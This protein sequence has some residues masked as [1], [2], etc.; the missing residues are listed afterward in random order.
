MVLAVCCNFCRL[1]SK[2][3]ENLVR[4]KGCLI[5]A[6]L[7]GTAAL[8]AVPGGAANAATAL[9]QLPITNLT[10]V[11]ADG[12]DGYVFL[13]T[14]T[15]VVVT[16]LNGAQV[17]TLEAGEAPVALATDNTH[18]FVA[19]AGSDSIGEFTE[20]TLGAVKTYALP[21]G[22]K[23]SSIAYQADKI[24]VSYSS[25]AV[26]GA[27]GYFKVGSATFVPNALSATNAWATA[28]RLAADPNPATQGTLVAADTGAIAAYNVSGYTGKPI[29]T[30]VAQLNLTTCAG[31]LADMA[32]TANG[33]QVVLACTG[34]TKELGFNAATLAAVATANYPGGA[35]PDAIAISDDNTGFATGTEDATAPALSV[36]RS[37]ATVPVLSDPLAAANET[38]APAGLS[39]T[40][41]AIR[42][43]A[44]LQNTTSG[45]YYL[46]VLEFPQY[47]P[48][49]ISI[50]PVG[51][52]TFKAG[53]K[54]KLKG[55]LTLGTAGTAAVPA[56]IKLKIYRQVFGTN[57]TSGTITTT[58]VA[59]GAYTA[60][61]IPPKHGN[62]TYLAYYAGGA[63]APAYHQ[64]LVHVTIAKPALALTTSA[65]SVKAGKTVTV[66]AHLGNPHTNR[67][68][69]IYAQ[70]KGGAKKVIKHANVNAKGV[71]S[72]SYKITANTTFTVTFSGDSWYTA[73][74]AT[75]T[76]KG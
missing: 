47:K 70:P 19:A 8:L 17:G 1:I 64:C 54:V 13:D 23:P 56:G 21:A 40:P 38:V 15:S 39:W 33:G 18:V 51:G 7:F 67:T 10:Q 3:V 11:L 48:S 61:D 29:G 30:P 35:T 28:P 59:G 27:V 20:A 26:T 75:A 45:A 14:A 37:G 36:F 52:D 62:Y 57:V 41:D 46:D 53:T 44:V 22:D 34:N 55:T 12:A 16:N 25:P 31:M 71:L 74:S 24:W 65:K 68:V 50:N 72:V 76:V 49:N 5:G 4:N 69:I 43:A 42:L 58:T 6:A 66:T 32:V 60:T 2:I 63:Y 9:P 73:A